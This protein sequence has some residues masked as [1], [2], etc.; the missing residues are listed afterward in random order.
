M[1]LIAKIEGKTEFQYKTLQGKVLNNKVNS[2][3]HGVVQ[4]NLMW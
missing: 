2:I 4:T 1:F 3:F